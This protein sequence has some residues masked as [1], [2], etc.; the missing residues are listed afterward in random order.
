[1]ALSEDHIK[2]LRAMLDDPNMA[3]EISPWGRLFKE[4]FLKS[5]GDG[6]T[7]TGFS[8]RYDKYYAPFFTGAMGAKRQDMIPNQYLKSSPFDDEKEMEHKHRYNLNLNKYATGDPFVTAGA[9][10]LGLTAATLL[11]GGIPGFMVGLGLKNGLPLAWHL[12]KQHLSNRNASKEQAS[13][14]YKQLLNRYPTT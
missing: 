6:K 9:H 7:P 1:M 3:Q 8:K 12:A 2:N 11:G 10:G 4:S 14:Y 5:Y 13:S